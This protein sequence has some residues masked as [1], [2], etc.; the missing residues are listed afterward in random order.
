MAVPI[1]RVP[2]GGEQNDSLD[3]SEVL[4]TVRSLVLG[5]EPLSAAFLLDKAAGLVRKQRVTISLAEWAEAINTAVTETRTESRSVAAV[6]ATLAEVKASRQPAPS[7]QRES[8]ST[9]HSQCTTQNPCGVRRLPTN[10]SRR[11]VPPIDEPLGG[12]GLRP[13][14]A[15][16]GSNSSSMAV[17]SGVLGVA[18]AQ[19]ASS[20]STVPCEDLPAQVGQ[21]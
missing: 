16:A 19:S 20:T 3:L 2:C 8:S 11:A 17:R 6:Q 10:T 15:P 18:A 7:S 1:A 4:A 12:R 21:L 9:S 14:A 5:Q 13:P